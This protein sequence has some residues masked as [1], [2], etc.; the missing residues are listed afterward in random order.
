MSD[1]AGCILGNSKNLKGMGNGGLQFG[2]SMSNWAG[3]ILGNSKNLKGM[4]NGEVQAG[5]MLVVAVREITR[6]TTSNIAGCISGIYPIYNQQYTWL[7]FG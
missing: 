7:H 3:C 1:R 5:C 2:I 4:G 6:F